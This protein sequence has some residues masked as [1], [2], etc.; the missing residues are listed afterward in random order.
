MLYQVQTPAGHV[1]SVT[2]KSAHDAK[3]QAAVVMGYRFHDLFRAMTVKR[4]RGLR[5]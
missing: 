4:I 3:F 5:H 2:A 1:V